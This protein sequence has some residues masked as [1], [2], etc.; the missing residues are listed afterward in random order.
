MNR[1]YVEFCFE[2][3]DDEPLYLYVMAYSEQQIKDMF[4]GY[5]FTTIDQ[6]D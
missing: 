5:E 6:T 3:D 4:Q 1:Y 2:Q